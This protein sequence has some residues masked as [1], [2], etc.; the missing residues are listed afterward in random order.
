MKNIQGNNGMIYTIEPEGQTSL[1]R[2]TSNKGQ[3]PLALSG[4]F[5]KLASAEDAVTKYLQQTKHLKTSVK[6]NMKEAV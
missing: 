2:I 3:L 5:T 1:L 6:S 4:F